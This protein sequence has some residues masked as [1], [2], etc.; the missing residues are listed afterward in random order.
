MYYRGHPIPMN[1]FRAMIYDALRRA[2]DMLWNK[3]IWVTDPKERS[4]I[5][6][7]RLKDDI[8]FIKR[9]I[10]FLSKKSNGL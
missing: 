9:G 8:T 3:L 2:E 6:L 7:D 5:A 4:T 1:M 10:S